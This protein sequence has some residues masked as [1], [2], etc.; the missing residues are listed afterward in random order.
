M[1]AWEDLTVVGGETIQAN[2][3]NPAAYFYL[4]DSDLLNPLKVRISNIIPPW[5][6]SVQ[7]SMLVWGVE[8]DALPP[9]L[10][11]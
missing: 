10:V 5:R 4:Y 11:P 1:C 7:L 3:I 6:C 9:T 2:Y 8:A